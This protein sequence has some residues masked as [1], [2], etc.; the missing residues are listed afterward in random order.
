ME[1]KTY[2]TAELNRLAYEA[3]KF[4]STHYFHLRQVG[5]THQ[6]ALAATAEEIFRRTLELSLEPAAPAPAT[7]EKP[8]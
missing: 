4:A 6:L 3:K 1:A 7:E 5:L 8:A 2:T